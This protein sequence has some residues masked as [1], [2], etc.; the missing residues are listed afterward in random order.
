MRS[1][2][3]RP[4]INSDI[5]PFDQH[6]QI[7]LLVSFA[8]SLIYCFSAKAGFCSIVE[9]INP[10]NAAHRLAV[11]AG[12]GASFFSSAIFSFSTLFCCAANVAIL[13]PNLSISPL[14]TLSFFFSA[15]LLLF[16][17]LCLI[18]PCCSASASSSSGSASARLSSVVASFLL[19]R[20]RLADF[21]TRADWMRD[22]KEEC[23]MRRLSRLVERKSSV[24]AASSR[25]TFWGA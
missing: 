10:L 3:E 14:T 17:L 24:T 23:L 7:M 9:E 4:S 25:K 18:L 5:S 2:P 20:R 12:A 8:P 13:T 19:G 15:P 1:T 16:K 11:G 22:T 6:S 21:E